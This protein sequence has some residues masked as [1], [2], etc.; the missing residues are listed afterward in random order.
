[1]SE[2]GG[3][4]LELLD[5]QAGERILD[6]GCGEGTLTKKIAERGATVLGIDNSPEM[7]A[8]AQA[9]GV[10]AQLLAA[11]AISFSEEFD[12]AFS[13]AALHWVLAKEQ[14]AAAIFRALRPGG[15]FVGEMGGEGNLEKLREALDDELIGRGYRPPSEAGNWYASPEEFAE[16]YEE[17]GFRDVDARLIERP[18]P[19][20]H[21]IAAWVT[22]FRKGWLDRAL[23]PEGERAEI[24]DAVA[25]RVGSNMA[26]YVRLRFIMRKPN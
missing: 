8:A 7:V 26:D 19:I 2:L 1:M 17:A 15:R 6:V 10:D 4:A 11:E 16:V 5:P 21:G 3:A 25:D 13:N 14:A 24:A 22:A 12:A 18:T 20:D 23:V 9:N